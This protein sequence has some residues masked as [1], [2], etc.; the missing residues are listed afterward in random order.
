MDV[1]LQIIFSSYGFEG[2]SDGEMYQQELKLALLAEELGFDAVWPTE[3][4]FYDYSLCPDNIELLAWVAAK[5]ERI[6]VG[7][8]AVILPWNDPLRVAEKI[9]LLDHLSGG[10]VRFGMGRGLSRREFEG[11]G[12]T[13]MSESRE[14]FDEA[15]KMIVAALETG[16]IEGDGPMF[17]QARREIRP[18]PFKSFA[19]RIYAVANSVDSVDACAAVG[20]RM[21][22]FAEASWRKRLPIIEHYRSQYTAIHGRPAPPPLIA[23]FTYCSHDVAHGKAVAERA[24]STYLASLLEHYELMGDHLGETKGYGA[25][26]K[27]AETLR[28]IGFDKYVD[29][30]LAANAY[31]TPESM[32]ETFRA[33]YETVGPFELATCFQFG[34]IPFDEAEASMRLFAAEVLP[35]VKSW[36]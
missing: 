14:R 29:G 24:M 9:V 36:R 12:P 2:V 35:E 17:P 34:A 32:I 13:R 33:R 30:F 11:F 25:Y 31:G 22:M 23:D 19:D 1:G 8:A 18:R 10:R 16:F 7:T 21:I 20:G 5:T 15:S 27:Q 4:H 6:A 26:G 28:N 3:H